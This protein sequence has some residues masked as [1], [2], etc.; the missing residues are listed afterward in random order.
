MMI[1]RIVAQRRVKTAFISR[2]RG[3]KASL[4]METVA[5]SIRVILFAPFFK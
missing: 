4:L 2:L 3:W 1:A 5:A